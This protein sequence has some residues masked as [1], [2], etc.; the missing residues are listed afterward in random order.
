MKKEMNTVIDKYISQFPESIQVILNKIRQTIRDNAPNAAEKISYGMPTFWQG[1]NIV[2]F[3]AYKNHL[4]FYPTQS[5]VEAFADRLKDYKTSKGT[6]QFPYDSVDY[7][8]IA[9][10]TRFRIKEAEGG[11]GIGNKCSFTG[12]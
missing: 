7:D 4:G 5:G 9:D 2:H 6:I 10:I 1:E 11:R 12:K 3:A 8:L